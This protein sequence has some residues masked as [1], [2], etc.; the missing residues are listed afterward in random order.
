MAD[1]PASYQLILE[2]VPEDK[3][4]EIALFLSG[5]FSLPPSSTRGI[6]AS[7]PIALISEMTKAQAEAV[8]N[9]LTTSIP[10]GTNI[11]IAPEGQCSHASRLQWPRPPRI[12][13]SS[14]DEFTAT[15]AENHEAKCPVCGSAL[16]IIQDGNDI[17]LIT[18][19]TS[20]KRRS[21]DTAIRHFSVSDRDPLFSGVK[22]LAQETA[23]YASIRSLQAGDTGFWMDH[24]NSIFAP[25][26]APDS[27]PAAARTPN[28][29]SNAKRTSS[30]SGGL[31]AFMKPGAF[32]VVLGR[33][34]DAPTVKIVSEIMGISE[35][36]ARERCL[37]LGTCVA[38]DISLDEAQNLL[39]RFRIL[40]TRV[41]I[42][43]PS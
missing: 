7:G 32:A 26:P 14:L 36:D 31:A 8:L 30:K 35:A 16:H 4:P 5:C 39:A 43:R 29:S 15:E 1:S 40:G 10:P 18:A 23:K 33:T 19:A 22:P 28:D 21:S 38:R 24:T 11:H 17:Q 9:E 37:S 25:A 34:K 3:Q 20:E 2:K 27:T 12:Y 13:G 6:A 42:V 41:R